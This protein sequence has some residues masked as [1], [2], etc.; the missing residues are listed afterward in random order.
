MAVAVYANQISFTFG[1]GPDHSMFDVYIGGTLWQ[2]YDGYSTT[3][4][5]RTESVT[6]ATADKVRVEFRNRPEKNRLSS[7]YK[8]RF[9]QVVASVDVTMREIN[10]TYDALSRLKNAIYSD[11][12]SYAYQFD[13]AGNRTQEQATIGA[14]T[15]T[16]NWTY[17]ALNQIT[18]LQI[19]SNPLV[20]FTYDV[21]GNLLSDGQLTYTWDSAN[22]LKTVNNGSYNT[23]FAYNGDNNRVSKSIGALVTRYLLDTQ[24]GL[25]VVLRE[26]NGATIT[27]Y[28]HNT[29]GIYA[30]EQANAWDNLLQDGLGSV[31]MQYGTDVEATISHSPYGV[32]FDKIG[33]FTGTFG[34]AGEQIDEN[35]LSYNR[36][37]YYSPTIGTF[38]G[39]D[40]FEGYEDEPLSLNGYSYVHGNPINLTDASGENP[41]ALLGIAGLVGNLLAGAIFFV[42]FG[43]LYILIDGCLKL[44]KEIIDAPERPRDLPAIEDY[45]NADDVQEWLRKQRPKVAPTPDFWLPPLPLPTLQAVTAT[46]QSP[47]STPT[48][49]PQPKTVVELGAGDYSNAIAIKS[50]NPSTRVIA[51]NAPEDLEEGKLFHSFGISNY[52]TQFYLG[53]L[54]AK[55]IGVEVGELTPILNSLVPSNIAD[56]V[57]SIAPTPSLA[58]SFGEEAARIAKSTV[59]TTI[60]VTER[61][62]GSSTLFVRGFNIK[63]PNS[64]F[65][66]ISG[67]P[68]GNISKEFEAGIAKTQIHYVNV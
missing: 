44:V 14:T 25:A 3:L 31:R 23:H 27:N 57:F 59:G 21:Q 6:L 15:S 22:R 24:A 45:P 18:T 4:G 54:S 68:Y 48:S 19:N 51:T 42:I 64:V 50:L 67:S 41:L 9:K 40:P 32:E 2:S 11:N 49:T 16:A 8:L 46:P 52:K 13:L 65:V 5:E 61:G 62:S 53:W 7:G 35:E 60:A 37:R 58:F 47:T 55:S 1:T 66:E 43:A 28:L 10:Y 34:Y 30:V 38:T 63:R 56:I 20:N 29:T 39:L 17:N 33:T 26:T 12:R 36:A